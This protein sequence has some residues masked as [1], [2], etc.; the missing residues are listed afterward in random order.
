MEVVRVLLLVIYGNNIVLTFK[1]NDLNVPN[2]FKLNFGFRM[3]LKG[4]IKAKEYELGS[5]LIQNVT[6]SISPRRAKPLS[7]IQ[8]Y[9]KIPKM[10]VPFDLKLDRCSYGC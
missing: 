10:E 6:V 5:S 4:D 9:N 7:D 2:K 8:Q 1:R 3:E